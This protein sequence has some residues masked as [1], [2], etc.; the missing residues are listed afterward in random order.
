MLLVWQALDLR[1]GTLHSAVNSGS[2]LT[3]A[4]ATTSGP[5]AVRGGWPGSRYC[6]H[7]QDNEVWVANKSARKK[8]RNGAASEIG[9]YAPFSLLRPPARGEIAFPH[10][11]YD[12]RSRYLGAANLSNNQIADCLCCRIIAKALIDADYSS[13]VRFSLLTDVP[14]S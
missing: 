2:L 6:R 13:N 11:G 3:T 1:P 5:A 4:G 9:I 12:N 10:H 8:A 14:Y 7:P